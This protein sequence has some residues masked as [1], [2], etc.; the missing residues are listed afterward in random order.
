[1]SA[2]SGD[3]KHRVV[4]LPDDKSAAGFEAV[5][6]DAAYV[7]T[8]RRTAATTLHD[9]NSPLQAA[10]W[11]VDLI[12]RG[13]R[14]DSA[15]RRD[16]LDTLRRELTRLKAA[17]RSFLSVLA[18]PAGAERIDLVPLVRDLMRFISAEASLVDVELA[19][20]LPDEEVTISGQRGPLGTALL[21][22][23]V[24][25]L[26]AMPQGGRLAI[27]LKRDDGSVHLA[28]SETGSSIDH[29][30]TFELDFSVDRAPRGIG[31][32][33]AH[34]VVHALGG[35]IDWERSPQGGSRFQ[36]RLPAAR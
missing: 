19:L 3:E 21:N 22:L 27:E 7:Q 13:L 33:V 32:Y 25:A 20:T 1:M 28:I 9:F 31:L 5:L 4:I 6:R 10:V 24:T 17:T 2:S 11:A 26:D 8:L 36:I 35:E 30:C 18:P 34:S 14:G 12:E 23:M 15:A 29:V 16:Y